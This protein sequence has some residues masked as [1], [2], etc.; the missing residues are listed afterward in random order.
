M[1]KRDLIRQKLRELTDKEI[2]KAMR[3][4]LDKSYEIFRKKLGDYGADAFKMAGG[5]GILYKINEKFNRMDHL[6][7]VEGDPNFESVKD[8]IS[9][10]SLYAHILETLIEKDLVDM[11]DVKKD[12]MKTYGKIERVEEDEN[13]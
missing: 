3:D 8:T 13:E 12:Y 11:D 1:R 6:L 2:L 9:D 4:T 5:M 10:L 7:R